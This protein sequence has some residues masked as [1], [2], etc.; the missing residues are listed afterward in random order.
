MLSRN[1][2]KNSGGAGVATLDF[3]AFPGLCSIV[4]TRQ[5]P[6]GQRNPRVT[7]LTEAERE[8]LRLVYQHMT[9][10]DIARQIGV[11]PHTVDMRLRQAIR[12]LEVSNRIEAAR[13]LVHT[14]I[15]LGV[16][17]PVADNRDADAYQELI[18]QASE[19]AADANSATI[20]APASQEPGA[21]SN[22]SSDPNQ[23]E[24]GSLA[25]TL[26]PTSGRLDVGPSGGSLAQPDASAGKI[27]Q[28]TL[29]T[30]WPG[31]AAP[32]P[33]I[34]ARPLHPTQFHE[35]RPWGAKNDLGIGH[36]LGWIMAISM[37]SALSFGGILAAL[38]ALKAL[39]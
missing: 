33:G 12:K 18:Y 24:H 21:A 32:D 4:A 27:A 31:I 19:I 3:A 20:G 38:A 39:L 25:R 30:D 37:A 14:E 13:A 9:S 17:Q 26:H 34:G 15:L 28:A 6:E 35:T 22:R 1:F 23:L 11:S 36:R 8:C 5:D 29:A 2:S 16:A 10:K 7:L